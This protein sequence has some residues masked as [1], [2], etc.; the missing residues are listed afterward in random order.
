MNYMLYEISG[1]C[2]KSV[3]TVWKGENGVANITYE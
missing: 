1:E 3:K 2:K